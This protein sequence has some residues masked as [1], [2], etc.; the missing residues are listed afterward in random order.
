MLLEI[1]DLSFVL[2]RAGAGIERA[3]I[4]TLARIRIGFTRVQAI[5]S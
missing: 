4:A 2:F 3:K 5:L 1:L